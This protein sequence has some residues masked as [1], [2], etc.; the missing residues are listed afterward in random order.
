ML[1]QF[2]K[3]IRDLSLRSFPKYEIIFDGTISFT[4]VEAIKLRFVTYEYE[5]VEFLVR[6][7]LFEKKLNGDNVASHLLETIML[8]LG[9]KLE[10]WF[11]SQQDRASTNSAAIKKIKDMHKSATPTENYCNT[12]TLSNAGN[13]LI[14]EENIPNCFNFRK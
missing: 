6:V 7:T 1:S 4:E 11:T 14:K 5:I 10:D 8:R 3:E 13:V 2:I 12:H 9:L